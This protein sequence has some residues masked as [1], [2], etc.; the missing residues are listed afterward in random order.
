MSE[1][2]AISIDAPLNDVL[3]QGCPVGCGRTV[4]PKKKL[5]HAFL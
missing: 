2:T 3:D 1:T 4:H 5:M